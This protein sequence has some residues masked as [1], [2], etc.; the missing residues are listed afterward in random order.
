MSSTNNVEAKAADIHMCCASCGIAEVDEI[1][2]KKC[3]DCDLVR[4]CSDKCQEDHRPNH[5]AVC[6][7]RATELR[8]D[9]LF[10]QPESSHL[11]DCPI[12]FLPLS[13][14]PNKFVTYYC[15]S[16]VI[17]HGCTAA[18]MMRQKKEGLPDGCPFCR[19]LYSKSP[20]ETDRQKKKRIEANDPMALRDKGRTHYFDGDYESAFEYCSKAAELGD[21]EAHCYLYMMYEAG[22]GVEK[23]KG[24]ETYHLEVAAIGGHP[25]AIGCNEVALAFQED[26][27]SILNRAVKHWII[28]AKLG[29][30]DS[31][32]R[33][34]EGFKDG[35]VSKEEFASALRG[36]QAAVDATKSPQRE[37]AEKLVPPRY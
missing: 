10:R 23:D 8:E 24:K 35:F 36:H 19:Q 4:Y 32:V 20:E 18:N 21:M 11:G 25:R 29:D 5:E 31:I 17:C 37:E 16:K 30:D 7:E 6:K 33:L 14:D 3:D 9:I 26:S 2:L 13:L 34:K 22:L 28:A 15:C 27:D 1:K 12:C